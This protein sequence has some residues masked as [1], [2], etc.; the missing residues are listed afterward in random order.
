MLGK[1]EKKAKVKKGKAETVI[2]AVVGKAVIPATQKWISI[3]ELRRVAKLIDD[4]KE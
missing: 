4:N 2:D 1:K 3:D